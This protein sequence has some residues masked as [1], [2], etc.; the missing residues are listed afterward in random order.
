MPVLAKNTPMCYN[1]FI[2]DLL[3]KLC[4]FAAQQI[5][6]FNV[7]RV[8]EAN[9]LFSRRLYLLLNKKM[10]PAALEAGDILA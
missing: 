8:D 9:L 1:K 4:G 7:A 3:R 6:S 5:W 2:T 10:E